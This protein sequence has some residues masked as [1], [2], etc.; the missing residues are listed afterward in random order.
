MLSEAQVRRFR[1]DGFVA[2]EGVVEPGAIE[3]L[4]AAAGRIVEAFDPERH[5]SVFTTGDR[6]R[7]RDRYFF[8]SAEAVH[9][10]LEEH[11]VDAEGRLNRPK[12]RAVNKI[13]HALHDLDPAFRAFCRRPEFGAALRALGIQDPLLWQTMYIFKQPGIGGE[14]RWHQDASY[15]VTEPPSVV[16]LWVALED[17]DRD[18]G[19]LWMQPGGHRSPLRER[20]DADPAAATGALV[21][22]DDT[23]WPAAGEGVALEVPAGSVVLFHDHMPHYSSQNTSP[24]SRHAFTM[25]C[26][27][28]GARWSASNWLQRPTLP[29]FQL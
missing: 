8:D 26:A 2:V 22:L 17:A 18:N 29:P 14:V 15:L 5:R 13:G 10:F 23:P 1:E 4:R 28:A 24:R 20:F 6:D 25:H 16:G 12:A 27:P 7:G 9:C 3:A 11:A 21:A 19:C